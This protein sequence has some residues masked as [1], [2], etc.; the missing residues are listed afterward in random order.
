MTALPAL[1]RQV[2]DIVRT[3]S[4][5]WD[6]G[7]A[8]KNGGNISVNVT[9]IVS[10][11]GIDIPFTGRDRMSREQP[12]LRNSCFIVTAAGSCMRD[13]AQDPEGLLLLLK[14][15]PDT[16]TYT[17]MPI[18]G[19]EGKCRPTSELPAHLAIHSGFAQQQSTNRAVVHAHV[20]NLIALT[21]INKLQSAQELSNIVWEMHPESLLVLPRGVG[22]VP[23]K[24]TGSEALA[25]ATVSA[26]ADRDV[27]LW[28]KHGAVAAGTSALDAFDK[29]DVA[30]KS[31]GIYIT[32][33]SC[34]FEPEGLTDKQIQELKDAFSS[35]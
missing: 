19:S 14:V 15:E 17:C 34:G 18:G 33:K 23:Y 27:V 6:R 28:E 5:L 29:L 3:A 25:E 4:Y 16:Q 13:I 2:H 10:E 24:L 7:W 9:D 35:S 11:P 26:L 31:A 8:E 20:D 21:H 32:C 22:F 30:A 1:E 12:L